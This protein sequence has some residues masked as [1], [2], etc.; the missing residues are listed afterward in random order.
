MIV[1]ATEIGIA[2]ETETATETE[3]MTAATI[4]TTDVAD[5]RQTGSN[6][7]SIARRFHQ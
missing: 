1:A 4:T 6:A 2:A 3:I 7:A 5:L